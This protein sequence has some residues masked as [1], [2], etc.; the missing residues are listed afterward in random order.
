MPFDSPADRRHCV[1]SPR[2]GASRIGLRFDRSDQKRVSRAGARVLAKGAHAN[3]C[4]KQGSPAIL[5]ALG[6]GKTECLKLLIQAG[7][8]SNVKD[9]GDL[10]SMALAEQRNR[11]EILRILTIAGATEGD[12]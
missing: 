4:A 7:V 11:R 5:W 10:A 3:A 12:R 9:P 2:F 1:R 8:D 6:G